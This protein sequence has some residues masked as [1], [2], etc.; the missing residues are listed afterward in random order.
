MNAAV[1]S[2]WQ[3]TQ[4]ALRALSPLIW[5][6]IAGAAVYIIWQR[7]EHID[8]ETVWAQ[9]RGLGTSD[10]LLAIASCIASYM[11]VGVYEG[12]A[13]RRATGRR[14]RRYSLLTA[15]IANPIGHMVGLA[16]ISGGALRYRLYSA[17]GL[18]KR[19]VGAVVLLTTLPHVLGIWTLLNIVLVLEAP[20][21]AGLLR[22]PTFLVKLAAV[23]S[24]MGL[25][26]YVAA[27]HWRDRPLTIGNVTFSLP[28]VVLTLQ[29]I[30]FGA[31]STMLVAS[32]MYLC[33]PEE[34]HLYWIQFIGAYL[35]ALLLAQISHVPAGLGVLEA[36]LLLMLPKVPPGKLIGA[37]LAYRFI[38]EFIPLVLA[39]LLLL[40][41][42]G[43]KR[44]VHALTG[45][46]EGAGNAAPSSKRY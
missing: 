27:N 14:M 24:V 5:S 29:Q 6:A 17:V 10:I 38:F 22:V 31:A 21:V 26:A 7:L 39:A 40:T 19:D 2:S 18:S 23:I 3:R 16:A 13:V 12:I 34:L 8:G 43:M 35:L 9:V 1:V 20:I 15:W 42:E 41:R 4:S 25:L 46:E 37:L 45:Q 36:S 33:M 44:R 28:G 32:I 30:V 11:L